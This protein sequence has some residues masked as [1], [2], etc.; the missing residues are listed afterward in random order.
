MERAIKR[1][2][3]R[4]EIESSGEEWREVDKKRIMEKRR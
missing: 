3:R 4:R 2:E 1:V